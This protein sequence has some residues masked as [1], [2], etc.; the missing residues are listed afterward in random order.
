MPRIAEKERSAAPTKA[1]TVPHPDG[2]FDPVAR[3]LDVI[4]DRWTLVLVRHLLDAPRG[5]Q[6]LRKRTGIAP[7][8]LSS[9]LRGLVSAGFVETVAEGSR[10]VYALTEQGRSLKPIITSIARWW[11]RH[12]LVDL[13]ID[14][15]RF[16]ETS[17]QS[18]MDALPFMVRE[19]RAR[20]VD[21]IFEIRLSGTGGGVWTVR[22]VDGGCTVTSG[23]AE[24]ADVR[25]TADAR[26]WCGLALG[27]ANASDLYKR[28]FITKEGGRQAMDHYFH[29]VTQTPPGEGVFEEIGGPSTATNTERSTT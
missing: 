5:F 6:E 23:F 28:G 2:I 7:R 20:G 27:L 24:R 25:Y 29:Q 8:V 13:D 14:A 16:T 15:E 18:V 1:G 21:I 19:E 17:A 12:G 9:R 10:S 3:G 4:G 26:I 11:I 22:I